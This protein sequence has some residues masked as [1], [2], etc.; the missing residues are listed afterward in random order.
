[1]RRQRRET[2]RE[3]LY[4]AIK[5]QKSARMVGFLFCASESFSP[6]LEWLFLQFRHEKE[7]VFRSS[8]P[9]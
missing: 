6:D 7:I 2:S 1:M 5:N 8:D 9:L 3:E 4:V